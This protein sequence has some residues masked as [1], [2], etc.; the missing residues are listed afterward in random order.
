MV[1]ILSSLVIEYS[2]WEHLRNYSFDAYKIVNLGLNALSLIAMII[3]TCYNN[4]YA[5][6]IGYHKTVIFLAGIIMIY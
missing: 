1:S 4:F 5:E 6:N 3:M 2:I